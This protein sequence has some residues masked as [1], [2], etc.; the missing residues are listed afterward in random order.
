MSSKDAYEK[1][2][3]NEVDYVPMTSSK[4]VLRRRSH[5]SIHRV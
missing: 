2:V 1:L 3:A 5:S 4:V